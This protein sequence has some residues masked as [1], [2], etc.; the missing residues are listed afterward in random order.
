MAFFFARPDFGYPAE[1]SCL[2]RTLGSRSPSRTLLNPELFPDH[3]YQF[4]GTHR[5]KALFLLGFLLA[6]L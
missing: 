2:R 4:V 5:V 3:V 6:V 1:H